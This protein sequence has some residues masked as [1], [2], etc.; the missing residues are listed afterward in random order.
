MKRHVCKGRALVG[1][2]LL[3]VASIVM[4]FLGSH[5]P[6]IDYGAYLSRAFSD[7][8]RELRDDPT[9]SIPAA[10]SKA[11]QEMRQGGFGDRRQLKALTIYYNGD[12]DAWVSDD[13]PPDTI[14]LMSGSLTVKGD[15]S[16]YSA[17]VVPSGRVRL[18]T[19]EEAQAL[20]SSL[21]L[22]EQP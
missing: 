15:E 8:S 3:V 1:A 22:L 6:Y 20:Q 12:V 5:K 21:R 11:V 16:G 19:E 14:L 7:V 2:M 17:F 18:L 10:L 4:H 9:T 13:P